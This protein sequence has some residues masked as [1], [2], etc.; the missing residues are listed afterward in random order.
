MKIVKKAISLILAMVFM[1]SI[2]AISANAA[3]TES[4]SN[5]SYATANTLPL[6]G[7]ISGSMSKS[8]DVDYYKITATSNG[9]I[10]LKF[11]HNYVDDYSWGWRIS[12]YCYS[13]GNYTK[14]SSFYVDL[15]D[16]ES[17]SFA[18][19]GAVSSGVYY[20]KVEDR[21]ASNHTVGKNYSIEN[22]F[23][24]TDY[25]EK[26]INNE[27]ASATVAKLN[28]TY[29]G[30]INDTDDKDYYK[31]TTTSTGKVS[32]KFKHKYFNDS[33]WGWRVGIYYYSG[34]KY[35]ELS[36]YYV[37][38]TNSESIDL[39]NIG[40]VSSGIYYVKVEDRYASNHT[41]GKDYSIEISFTQTDYYEKEL[42]NDYYTATNVQ[43]NK[44]YSGV[45]NKS[46][47]KD[48]YK[49][50]ALSNGKITLKFNHTYVNDYSWGWRVTI[51]NY[52]NGNY[53]EISSK[54]IDLTESESVSLP[55][56]NSSISDVYFIKVEDRYTSDHTVGKEYSLTIGGTVP[57]TKYTVTYNANGGTISTSSAT[58]E[59]GK[60][61]TLPTPSKSG[62][63]CLGWSTSSSAT[64][65]SY[66]CGASYTPTKNITLYAVWKS[67]PMCKVT[68]DA[69]GGTVS[70]SS[71]SVELDA[72]IRFPQP[73]R[74]GYT[75]V[76][77]TTDSS[78]TTARYYCDRNYII[79]GNTVLYAVWTPKIET[80][81]MNAKDTFTVQYPDFTPV[82]YYSDDTNVATITDNGVVRGE[83]R[84]ETSVHAVDAYGNIRTTD[85]V[86]NYTFWQ[87]LIIILL[88]G[89]IWY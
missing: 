46:D 22:A 69:K 75:F 80:Y 78:A 54:Y 52:S 5:D 89:W 84:G 10:S 79:K 41:V 20:V 2:F 51:Y 12:I 39:A 38:L 86:V 44:T 77:W 68:Y 81:Y 37:D 55:D 3:T 67:V 23:A 64:S 82:R 62:Y 85:I 33:S 25:Y 88:F 26:E 11:K 59:S 72:S 49:I 35:N 61:V 70:P 30:V 24:Q 32:L 19:I 7:T 83:H 8:S 40:A 17:I 76:G 66:S 50:T 60:S 34:G 74:D 31:I 71:V 29:N 13:N 4:E 48:Y 1:M 21:Y 15:T 53:N 43:T 45:I 18:N 58:V 73:V 27:F 63:S 14:L 36:S 6:N 16:S 56:I 87:W 9:K 47:D 57:V 28:S 42:N 65:A